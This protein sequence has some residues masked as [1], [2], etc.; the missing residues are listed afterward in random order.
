VRARCRKALAQLDIV[1]E[2]ARQLTIADLRDRVQ[3]LRGRPLHLMPV[4]T[5]PGWPS[6]MWVET[7]HADLVLFDAETS[8]LHMVSIIAHEIG[9]IVLGHAGAPP[10]SA[11]HSMLGRFD[12]EDSAAAVMLRT[13][14]V[15]HDEHE[16]EVFATMVCA[17]TAGER[18]PVTMPAQKDA[19]DLVG[20]LLAA[21][22][23]P[24]RG[25]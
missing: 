7:E 5:G 23:D 21:M 8:P 20:R 4:V 6:G 11:A 18:I 25:R 24:P 16:A 19:Q 2:P 17:R 15:D 10:R 14:F 3:R 22:A 9:H 12:T 1:A 13:G